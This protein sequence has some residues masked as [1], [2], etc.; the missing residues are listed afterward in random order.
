MSS[1]TVAKDWDLGDGGGLVELVVACGVE[2]SF[3]ASLD[4]QRIVT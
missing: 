4:E 2:A 1:A 3:C